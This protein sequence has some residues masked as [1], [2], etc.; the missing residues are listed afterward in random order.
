MYYFNKVVEKIVIREQMQEFI[1]KIEDV[2]LNRYLGERVFIT[3][4]DLNLLA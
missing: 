1:E 2:L 4:D 3:K